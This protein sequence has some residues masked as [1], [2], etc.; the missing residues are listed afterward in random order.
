[1]FSSDSEVINTVQQAVR[2]RLPVYSAGNV[3]HVVKILTEHRPG[4]LVTDVS[5]DKATIQSMTARLKEHLPEFVTIA[6]SQHRDRP[7]YGLAHQS[8]QISASCASRRPCRCAI[9]LR[10]RSQHH[11]R[12]KNPES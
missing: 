2:G 11:R 3:V 6:V 5:E 7:R 8:R 4:V 12:F 1:V 10:L 9:S